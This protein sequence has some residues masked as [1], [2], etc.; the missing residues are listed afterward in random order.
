MT[1]LPLFDGSSSWT[2]PSLSS[3][4]RWA[5]ARRVS[6]DWETRDETL[7]S[8]GPGVRRGGEVVGFGFALED[9]SG[10][11][12]AFYLPIG[13]H[14]GGNLSWENVLAYMVE[15]AA[16]YRGRDVVGA[17]LS[18]ELDYAWELGIKF[19]PGVRYRDVQLAAPLC[20]ELYQRYNLEAICQ[21]LGIAGK[22]ETALRDALAAQSRRGKA[23]KNDLWRLHS[24]HVGPYAERDVLAPLEAMDLLQKDLEAQELLEVWDL[25]TKL[26]PILVRMRRKGVRV[27]LSKVDQIAEWSIK[28]EIEALA[29]VTRLTGVKLGI[30]DTRKKEARVDALKAIGVE[31]KL[32]ETGQPQLTKDDLDAI[33]HPVAEFLRTAGKFNYLRNTFCGSIRDQAVNGRIHTTFNQMRASKEGEGEGEGGARYGRLSSSDPN[34]QN[35]PNPEKDPEIGPV[36]RTIFLPEE[37]AE[38]ACLDF[39]QQE[40]RWLVAFAEQLGLPRAREAAQRFRDD[41]STDNHGMMRDLILEVTRDEATWGGK[42]GRTKAKIVGLGLGYG[43]G[44]AKL[45]HDLGLPTEVI[46]TKSGRLAEI[47]GPEGKRIMDAYHQGAPFVREFAKKL[48]EVAAKFGY[49]RT[50]LR[51][52]CRFPEIRPGVWDWCHKAGNRVVQGSSADQTKKAMVDADEAGMD[53]M[54][55]Q[56]HDEL[57]GSISNRDQARQLAEIM[58][59]AVPCNV[60][61]KVDIECGPSWGEVKGIDK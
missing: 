36:W 57:D 52:K 21:R 42:P 54:Q 41:P 30:E 24:K 34:L 60:P 15:Q 51:R 8:L 56:V 13:H 6:I 35:Q 38:W 1:Q 23:T 58:R 14:A 3:L 33:D 46:R 2:P 50:V 22:D 16:A 44:D 18:Y 48:E 17:N 11:R 49:V 37:G 27:D 26:L 43:M 53:W 25:E 59:A 45:C 20:N 12:R 39:S 47:A 5:D 40:P 9:D 61:H 7:T 19:R 4:P 29:E 10:N 32:T 55:L 31:L 28:R